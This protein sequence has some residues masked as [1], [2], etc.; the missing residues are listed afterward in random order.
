MGQLDELKRLL[1]P[2]SEDGVCSAKIFAQMDKNN[3]GKI[4]CAE[5]VSYV[6]EVHK[7]MSKVASDAD[8]RHIAAA[9]NNADVDRSGGVSMD[10]LKRMLGAKTAA[11]IKMVEDVFAS[12]DAN[13]DAVISIQEFSKL[14]GKALVQESKGIEVEW[15][16]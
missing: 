14:Y 5:F 11:E 2:N 12:V 6:L 1:Y 3:D 13:N 16:E 4:R 10:E 8:K 9:F 7:T 15:K